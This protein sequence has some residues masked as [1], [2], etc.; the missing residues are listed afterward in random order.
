MCDNPGLLR[1]YFIVLKTLCSVIFQSIDFTNLDNACGSSPVHVLLCFVALC[2]LD[3]QTQIN[4]RSVKKKKS[5]I[6]ECCINSL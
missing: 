5:N 6:T 2:D 3:Q 4:A 1:L